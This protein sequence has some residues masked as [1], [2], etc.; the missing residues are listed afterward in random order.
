MLG[1]LAG[2]AGALAGLAMH[3]IR[4]AQDKG[5]AEARLTAVEKALAN[6]RG[7]DGAIAALQATVS[8]LKDSVDGLQD[9]LS[10]IRRHLFRIQP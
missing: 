6:S 10:E 9:A 8:A 5:A 3:V 4:Y 7:A 2:C 1:A